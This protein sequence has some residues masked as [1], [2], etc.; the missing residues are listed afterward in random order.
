LFPT[1][2][3]P[4]R[5]SEEV[6]LFQ[7]RFPLLIEL[8]TTEVILRDLVTLIITPS[9]KPANFLPAIVS[10]LEPTRVNV[11][12]AFRVTDSIDVDAD[13]ICSVFEKRPEVFRKL[14]NP[15]LIFS[16]ANR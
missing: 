13:P 7:I 16:P 1:T 9:I 6:V 10:P 11:L 15:A 5:S 4:P 12:S 8:R 2:T 3:S 14:I